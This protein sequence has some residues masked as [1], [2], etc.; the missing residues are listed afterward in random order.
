MWCGGRRRS[1][2]T[3]DREDLSGVGVL[4]GEVRVWEVVGVVVAGVVGVVVVAVIHG[5]VGGAVYCATQS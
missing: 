1:A 5:S 3:C 2:N 4:L